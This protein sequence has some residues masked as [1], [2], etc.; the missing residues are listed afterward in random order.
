[1]EEITNKL[2]YFFLKTIIA[3]LKDESITVD[4][5]RNLAKVFLSLEPFTSMEDVDAK[6]TQFVGQNEQFSSLTSYL[7]AYESEKK[8]DTKIEKMRE[9][10]KNNNIEAALEV[11]KA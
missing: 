9:H 1:M 11:A 5:A 3:G 10:M 8:T 7:K 6:V 2:E 4:A